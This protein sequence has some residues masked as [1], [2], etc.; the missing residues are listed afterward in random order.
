MLYWRD[1]RREFEAKL[2]GRLDRPLR[3]QELAQ[4]A[5]AKG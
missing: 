5:R 2:D 3:V 4:R 1:G